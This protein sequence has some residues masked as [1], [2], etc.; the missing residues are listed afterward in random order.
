VA[1]PTSHGPFTKGWIK[2]WKTEGFRGRPDWKTLDEVIEHLGI[3]LDFMGWCEEH[4]VIKKEL[5]R[6]IAIASGENPKEGPYVPSPGDPV[7][8][9]WAKPENVDDLIERAV[10]KDD[11]RDARRAHSPKAARQHSPRKTKR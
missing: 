9:P 5:E 3:Q 7:D 1:Y 4:A 11:L 10:A 6:E 8:N 2:K